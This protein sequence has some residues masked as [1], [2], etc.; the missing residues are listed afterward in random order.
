[1]DDGGGDGGGD[2]GGSL[3]TAG[4]SKG[5]SKGTSRSKAPTKAG[6]KALD[7]AVTRVSAAREAVSAATN[8]GTACCVVARE[9]ETLSAPEMKDLGEK[10]MQTA[11]DVLE[12]RGPKA[13]GGQERGCAIYLLSGTAPEGMLRRRRALCGR[14][15]RRQVGP[16]TLSV[17]PWLR[18]LL[19][20]RSSCAPPPGKALLSVPA[21]LSSISGKSINTVRSRRSLIAALSCRGTDL[22]QLQS[23]ETQIPPPYPYTSNKTNR[24]AQVAVSPYRVRAREKYQHSKHIEGGEIV[25]RMARNRVKPF[26]KAL[27]KVVWGYSARQNAPYQA[28]D[29]LVL[30]KRF[31]HA[32]RVLPFDRKEKNAPTCV[33]A[34]LWGES[35]VRPMPC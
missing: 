10:G 34:S 11:T 12:E 4:C 2:D 22:G 29:K 31:F 30:A 1:M 27:V 16:Q 9:R 3:A 35:G 25:T 20:Y 14:V 7:L 21:A 18:E 17:P 33:R 6:L 26:P 19:L 32:K 28:L 8:R 24:C 5:T 13:T 15:R 23:T